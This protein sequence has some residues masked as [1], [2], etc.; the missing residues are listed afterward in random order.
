MGQQMRKRYKEIDIIKGLAIA[1]VI[2]GHSIIVYP[3]NLCNIAPYGFFHRFLSSAHMPLFFMISGFCFGFSNWKDYLVKKLRRIVLPYIVFSAVMIAVEL[4][5]GRF[6]NE[7][8]DLKSSVIGMLTGES[9]WFLYTLMIIFLVFPLIRKAF[10][11]RVIGLIA[12]AAIGALSL[13]GFIPEICNLKNAVKYLFYFA[14]GY[15]LK[16]RFNEDTERA[17]KLIKRVGILPVWLVSL[18]LW[19]FLAYRK[20]GGTSIIPPALDDIHRKLIALIGILNA[21]SFAVLIR[22]IRFFRLF[23]EAGKCSLQ[24]YLFNGYLLVASRVLVISVLHITSPIV[25]IAAN[26]ITSFFV[27]LLIIRFIVKPVKLLRTLTGMV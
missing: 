9:Y 19:I 25:I 10:E 17:V 11:N 20:F 14:I 26:F 18:A 1:M 15:Y 27:S 4:L 2:M 13:I 6:M 21:C 8:R 23:E 16:L 24:L 7:P 22:R 3:I 12:I 5:L